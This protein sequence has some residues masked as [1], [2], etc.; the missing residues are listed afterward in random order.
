MKLRTF[1]AALFG[2]WCVW[3]GSV[4]GQD[5]PPSAP[6][7]ALSYWTFSD[8][9]DWTSDLGSKPLSYSSLGVSDLGDGT[10]LVVDSTNA[11]WL[12]YPVIDGDQTNL[13]IGAPG[14]VA[15]WFAPSWSGTN[16]GG[17]GPGVWGRLIEA[18]SYTTNA[19]IGWWSLYTDPA[20]CNLYFSAQTNNGTSAVYLSA[21]IA[22]TTNKWHF[23]TL[24]Y[25]PTNASLYLDG[26]LATNQA[27]GV[28]ISP[29]ASA[30][31]NGFS[32]GSSGNGSNQA[33]GMFDDLETY[34]Y[35]LSAHTI[36]NFFS[37]SGV[38]YWANP[39]NTANLASAPFDPPY[40]SPGFRAIMGTGYVHQVSFSAGCLT[41]INVWMTNVTAALTNNGTMDLTFTIAGGAPDVAYDV[42]ATGGLVGNSITNAQWVW[43]GQGYA[44][45]TYVITNLP[46]TTAMFILGTPQDS[47]GDGLTDA[48]ETLV[49]KTDPNNQSSFGD[50][51]SDW[52]H[53]YYFGTNVMD[54]DA[55]PDGDGWTNLQEYQNGTNPNQFN[56][57]PP[58]RNVVAV[59]DGTG[60]NVTI[61]WISGGGPVTNYT[62]K[63]GSYDY[64]PSTFSAV[65]NVGPSTFSASVTLDHP[66][67]GTIYA[68]PAL[69]VQATFSNGSSAAS[70]PLGVSTFNPVLSSDMW[71]VRG[72]G[73]RNYLAVSALASNVTTLHFSDFWGNSSDLSVTNLVN[74]VAALPDSTPKGGAEAVTASGVF[75]VEKDFSFYRA[76]EDITSQFTSNAFVNAAAHMKENLKFL[77]RSADRFQAFSY[78]LSDGPNDYNYSRDASPT[79]YEYYGFHTFSSDLNYSVM[80]ELRPLKE[81]IL[82]S[83]F[84]YNPSCEGGTGAGY[85]I[86]YASGE[87]QRTLESPLYDYSGTGTESNL[88]LAQVS[89]SATWLYYAE[90]DPGDGDM[91]SFNIGITANSSHKFLLN[92]GVKNCYGLNESSAWIDEGPTVLSPGV[93]STFNADSPVTCYPQMDVPL[94]TG[95]NYYF[96]SQTWYLN[97]NNT[98]WLGDGPLPGAAPP[99]PGSPTFSI[100]NTSPLLIT[101][102]GQPITVSGWAKFAISNGYSNHYAYLEQYFDHAYTLD[103]N[104]AVT[105]NSAG[106]LSPYGEFFPTQPGPAAL[107]TLP[108]IDTGQRGT[109]VVNVIKIQLDVN[110]DNK[111][112]LSFGGPDNTS[113]NHPYRFWVN[114]DHDEPGKGGGLDMDLSAWGNPPQNAPD[115]TYGAI[116]CQRNLEDFARLGVRGLP[117]LSPTEGYS[118]TFTMNAIRGTPSINLYAAVTNSPGYLTDTNVAAAQ[119][120]AG[121]LLTTDYSNKLGTISSLVNWTLPLNFDGTPLYTNFLFEGAGIGVGE[122][123]MNVWQGTNIIAQTSAWLDLEDVGSMF[124][125]V[126][127]DGAPSSP[128]YS[129]QTDTSTY[130]TDDF[131]PLDVTDGNQIIAFV[132]GWRVDPWTAE[133]F[134]ESMFKRLYWAGYSGRYVAVRWPT[135]SV[136]TMPYGTEYLTFNRDEYIAFKCAKGVADYFAHLHDRF[137]DHAINV[138]AHSHGNVLMMEVLKRHLAAGQSPTHN[139]A[140]LQAALAAE[141]LVTNAPTYPEFTI[142]YPN[143]DSFYGYAGPVQNA[144]SGHMFN[145]FNTNDFGVVTAWQPN[146][147]LYK[148]DGRYEYQYL[149]GVPTQSLIGSSRTI[150][151]PHELMAFLSRPK[152]QAVGGMAGLGSP[153]STAQEVDLVGSYGFPNSWDAHSGE[154][155]YN[156]QRL[157]PFYQDLLDRLLSQ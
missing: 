142:G 115:Y 28:T 12:T 42:F 32:I 84:V 60:T 87:L 27:S 88:P 135:L 11:A 45:G 105:T 82:W 7:Y 2:G 91:A 62:V 151:D 95:T 33:Q 107:V 94:L 99:L 34:G 29:P 53:F 137:P 145:F 93:A 140:L 110:H 4:S 61:T 14:S 152:T 18:G 10:A 43:L 25:S 51:T 63:L 30:L 96:A 47:D 121:D 56:T 144:I 50:G 130:V 126:H 103:T 117:L 89:S 150:T 81:N 154:F 90:I 6:Y 113:E 37:G 104:G 106:V 131:I 146:Q 120:Q 44:C 123:V 20:G 73:G 143:S 55:D 124:E 119:L 147:L 68:E 72:P 36:S 41:N 92:S 24:T 46:G 21:P 75:G 108:D 15:F 102:L 22:W 74:G 9:N 66:V 8:T 101:G 70:N 35:V 156:I 26:T 100:T 114:N 109:G 40:P 133:N 132:H 79:N 76:E 141:C 149:L 86:D 17:S 52:W 77:L 3:S 69:L 71:V 59:V 39:L 85:Y 153:F 48:F 112:D 127:I 5:L 65:T 16:S 138:T 116:R 98:G 125:H 148:P 58:P 129:A 83:N 134:A 49:S 19:S 128:P 67:F 111:M 13:V 64:P 118:V 97:Y 54:P 157:L 136:E 31:T 23:V 139:Y 1:V 78:F 38:Q 122:L 155:N 80:Q 57:P